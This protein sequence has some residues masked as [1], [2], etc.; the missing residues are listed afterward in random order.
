V[1][2]SD[3]D[4]TTQ[5]LVDGRGR[6]KLTAWLSRNIAQHDRLDVADIFDANPDQ[7]IGVLGVSFS[8][9]SSDAIARAGYAT[10]ITPTLGAGHN[11]TPTG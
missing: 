9:R 11:S 8:R 1:G 2:F 7:P 3:C 4:Y 10:G 5:Q 6:A